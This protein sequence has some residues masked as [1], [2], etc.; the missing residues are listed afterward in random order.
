MK[1][2]DYTDYI[3]F[4]KESWNANV[5][6]HLASEFYGV[7]KFIRGK[8]SLNDIELGLLGNIENKTLLHLQCHFGMDSIS[9]A[10][11]GAKVTGVD[12]SDAAIKAA[13][14]LAQKT[15]TE[16]GF[17][18]CDIYSLPEHLDNKFDIVFT[19]YGVIGWLPDM[20]Q[21]AYIVSKYLKP[22]GTFVMVEFHPFVWM[23]DNDFDKVAYRYFNDEAIFEEIEGTYAD[24]DADIKKKTISWNHSLSEVI[25]NLISA[26]LEIDSFEEYDYS[27]YNCFNHTNEVSPGRFQIEK[28]GNKI[29][30]LYSIKAVKKSYQKKISTRGI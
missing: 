1:E 24:R 6:V 17:I 30:M 8:T 11:L 26:G 9:L 7:N 3:K 16:A 5:S 20:E 4:N 22:R 10:K 14:E 25:N 2:T 27:P 23:Y 13:K 28:F 12:F 15:N 21:W 18:C 29:P 19:S